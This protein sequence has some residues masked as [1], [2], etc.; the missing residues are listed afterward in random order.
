[1]K[2]PCLPTLSLAAALALSG[3]GSSPDAAPTAVASETTD[4]AALASAATSPAPADPEEDIRSFLLGEYPDAGTIR[5]ALAWKD[6][7]G[8][9]LDEAIVYLTGQYFCGSGGCSL[10]VLS[11]DGEGWRTVGDVS[12]TRTPV[13]VLASSSNGWRDLAVAVAGGGGPAGTM[14]LKF[15]G[16]A[17]PGNASIAELTD[18]TG[19]TLLPET[20]EMRTARP[21]SGPA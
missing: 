11:K 15:D 14:A 19:Q 6:L 4:A 5:Y 20:P 16:K 3:C 21:A 9:G 18:A 12:T 1:M 2:T 17:Y 8:D 7:N 10:L 13:S